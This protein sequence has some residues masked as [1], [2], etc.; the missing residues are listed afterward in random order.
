MKITNLEYI[1]PIFLRDFNFFD[2]ELRKLD[3]HGENTAY[4]L[5]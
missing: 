2:C 1:F 3:K 4:G 5:F